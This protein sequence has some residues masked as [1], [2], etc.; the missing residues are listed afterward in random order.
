M[1][2]IPFSEDMPG[3]AEKPEERTVG[4]AQQPTSPKASQSDR[5]PDDAVITHHHEDFKPEYVTGVKLVLVVAS[6][7]L[8]CFLML[9][10]TMVIST[11]SG[12][13]VRAQTIRAYF[14]LFSLGYSSYHQSVSFPC[15]CWLVRQRIPVWHVSSTIR[16]AS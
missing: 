1:P 7:A 16:I 4:L 3:A 14:S 2:P 5:A 9:V 13:V 10:D 12:V 11:V 8:G 15:R 6:V